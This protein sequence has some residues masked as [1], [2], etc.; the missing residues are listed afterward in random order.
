MEFEA[1]IKAMDAAVNV[2]EHYATMR[3]LAPSDRNLDQDR[4]LAAYRGPLK[5]GTAFP[6][7]DLPLHE[8]NVFCGRQ[9]ELDLIDEVL[10]PL[11][12]GI[13]RQRALCVYGIGGVG[14]SRI[15]LAY[16]SRC[17]DSF[18]AIFVIPSEN[19]IAVSRS[20]TRVARKLRLREQEQSGN[21]EEDNELVQQWLLES[22]M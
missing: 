16:A 22:G 2:L 12:K 11:L 18:D 13:I 3:K 17:R 10:S 9:T 8:D 6:C 15:A 21:A 20:F 4:D 1:T 19:N 7:H 14:K 5:S